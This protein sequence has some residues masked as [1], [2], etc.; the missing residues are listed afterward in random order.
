M[1][2]TPRRGSIITIFISLFLSACVTVP[3]SEYLEQNARAATALVVTIKGYGTGILVAPDK[4][5][6]VNHVLPVDIATVYFYE[7]MATIQ[8]DST[9]RIGEVIWR[10]DVVDLALIRIPSVTTPPVVISC[11]LTR[12]GTPVFLIG[13]SAYRVAW[14]ARYGNVASSNVDPDG[15]LL[16]HMTAS[17]G[18]SGAGV[19]DYDGILVGILETIQLSRSS[20][21]NTGISF[22]IP[23]SKICE[24]LADKI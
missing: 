20:G 6:T 7:G 22:M 3:R 1:K 4:I 10:S 19:F 11:K 15:S 21:G 5:L 12:M 24:E 8:S 14:T 9:S 16:L 18:D 2:N 13:H 23:G 17:Y